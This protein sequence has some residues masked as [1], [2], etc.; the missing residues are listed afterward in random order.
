MPS[1]S[2]GGETNGAT[3][4]TVI[5]S[6]PSISPAEPH[7]T[8]DI[9]RKQ[10][11]AVSNLHHPQPSHTARCAGVAPAPKPAPR[12]TSAPLTAAWHPP[13]TAPPAARTALAKASGHAAT[14]P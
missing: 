13:A 8:A 2:R 6:H 5:L 11:K 9:S 7:R 14:G 4:G 12:S 10:A 1:S 3:K